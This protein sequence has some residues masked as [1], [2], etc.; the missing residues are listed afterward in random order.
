MLRL[1]LILL[2]I[3][4]VVVAIAWRARDHRRRSGGIE[5]ALRSADPIT[6]AR[7]LREIASVGLR[8]WAAML[9]ARTREVGD[10]VEADELVWLVGACQWEPADEPEIVQLRLWAA[11][12]LEQRAP[13]DAEAVAPRAPTMV[14]DA[15]R[16]SVPVEDPPH[17]GPRLAVIS[18]PEAEQEPEAAPA[19]RPGIVD[20]IEEIVGSRVLALSFVPAD[21]GRFVA[22]F[23]CCSPRAASSGRARGR[24][25]IVARCSLLTRAY[26]LVVTLA[27]VVGPGARAGAA[28]TGATAAVASAAATAAATRA[29]LRQDAAWIQQAARADGAIATNPDQRLVWPYLANF[30]AMGLARSAAAG[31]R[32]AATT[33]W[34]WLGWYQ[35]HQDANGYVGDYVQ[36]ATG[37]WPNGNMDSTD[38]YAGTYLLAVESMYLATGDRARVLALR[39]GIQGAVRA[40]ESTQDVDGLTWAKPSWHV[41]YL[42]DQAETYAGLVAAANLG[43]ALGMPKVAARATLDAHRLRAGFARL[44]NPRVGAYDWAVHGNG[45]RAATNWSV[46]YPDAMQQAWAV[47][48]GLSNG[49]RSDRLVDTLSRRQPQWS[50]PQA[51]ATIG[52]A[53]RR[54]GY[55]AAATW[56]L[57]RSGRSP[58]ARIRSIRSA[59]LATHRAWPFT[60]GDAGQLMVAEAPPL[61]PTLQAK[62]SAEP[63][64]AVAVKARVVLGLPT[65]SGRGGSATGRRERVVDQP[66]ARAPGAPARLASPAR[67]TRPARGRAAGAT[68]RPPRRTSPRRRARRC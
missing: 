26:L 1:L 51:M 40:I 39:R 10:G 47:A 60:S 68:T 28:E 63:R 66:G 45:A 14:I 36:T 52:S 7:A 35:A 56:A 18:E 67:L 37:L 27:L 8:P 4:M 6:R 33:A 61:A 2:G 17:E 64:A 21:P 53:S 25:R 42:M 43:D 49:A 22:E 48:F 58:A 32:R 59:A 41:K 16:V 3:A 46:L 19:T 44:W 38:A 31:D 11:R 5:A 57:R 24:H 12:R 55:W 15:R 23:G 34:R 13:V 9:L 65:R 50:S 29:S 30:A 54:V 20:E 62:R